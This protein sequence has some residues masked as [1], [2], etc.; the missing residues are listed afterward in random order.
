MEKFKGKYDK[1]KEISSKQAENFD[2][3]EE[4]K[5]THLSTIKELG[6]THEELK[7]KYKSKKKELKSQVDLNEKHLKRIYELEQKLNNMNI[8]L[9]CSHH[10]LKKYKE[11]SNQSE[12]S[13][14]FDFALF[15]NIDFDKALR[16]NFVKF[17]CII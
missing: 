2:K 14:S 16:R 12:V 6:S 9:W 3:D 17:R 8:D 1:Y 4:A 10:K 7:Q 5:K 11:K 13:L 15:R